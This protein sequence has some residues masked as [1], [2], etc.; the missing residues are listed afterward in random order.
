M[1][2]VR[3]VFAFERWGL[4]VLGMR[5]FWSEGNIFHINWCVYIVK[6]HQIIYLIKVF[7]FHSMYILSQLK[8]KSMVI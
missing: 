1:K 6:T 2:E 5:S 3:T 8:E 7:A 4:T